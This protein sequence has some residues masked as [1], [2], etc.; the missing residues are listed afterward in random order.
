VEATEK[1]SET[2]SRE[3]ATRIV[4]TLQSESPSFHG[5]G[6][7][8]AENLRIRYDV[9]EWVRDNVTPGMVTLETGCGYSSVVFAAC[10][11]AHT[12]VSPAPSEHANV[13]AWCEQKGVPTSVLQFENG[14]SEVVL[15]GLGDAPID[16]MLIDGM[17]AYPWPII[18]FFFTADRIKV[19]GYLM[20]DDV[21]L[22][23][24]ETLREFVVR[25]EG[26]WRLVTDLKATTIFQK[27]SAPSLRG[28]N[29]PEQPWGAKPVTRWK[30]RFRQLR[31]RF[32]G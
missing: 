27:L 23:S 31:Q 5:G 26:R 19:G 32:G 12:S 29:W 6:D 28:L 11:A 16:L 4:A 15:P 17:H 30:R 9:L 24:G 2:G 10:G 25:E 21:S 20:I 7:E 22:R 18:D 3:L 1:N 8:P 14:F 13:R